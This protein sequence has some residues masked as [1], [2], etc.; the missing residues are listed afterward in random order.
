[1]TMG[2][3]V[4][5]ACVGEGGAMELVN[6]AWVTLDDADGTPTCSWSPSAGIT[7][8]THE[9]NR[10]VLHGTTHASN[11]QRGIVVKIHYDTGKGEWPMKL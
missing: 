3:F 10:H 5:V 8:S 9:Y 4:I 6:R 1:M 2:E 7:R 11:W